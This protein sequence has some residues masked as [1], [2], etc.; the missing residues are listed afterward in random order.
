MKNYEEI[1][2]KIKLF[3]E[4]NDL[5]ELINYVNNNNIEFKN[6]NNQ[7]FDIISYTFSLY[8]KNTI[9][10]NLKDF[11]IFHYDNK[12]AKVTHILNNN[13]LNE[14]KK[15]TI[16]NNIIFKELNYKYFDILDYTKCLYEKNIISNKVYKYVLNHYNEY[17][18]REKIIEIIKTN[19]VIKLKSYIKSNNID[20]E[21]L[22][23]DWFDIREYVTSPENNI[24]VRMKLFVT[25]Y[26]DKK[27]VDIIELLK[28]NDINLVKKYM[29]KNKI[30]LKDLDDTY[31]SII[32]YVNCSTDFVY[33]NKIKYFIISYYDKNRYDV[34]E[35]IKND[36]IGQLKNYIKSN[37]IE[38]KSL[39]DKNFNLINY[40]NSYDSHITPKMKYFILSHYNK[41]RYDIVELIR[42]GKISYLKNYIEK[43]NINLEDLNDNNFNILMYINYELNNISVNMKTFVLSH[44]NKKRYDIV[45]RIRN[46][47][48]NELK[49]FIEKNDIELKYYND[50]YFDIIKYTL[51]L[52]NNGII[53]CII[54]NYVI[55]AFD[56][57]R[58][59]TVEIIKKN[60]LNELKKYI[61]ENDI[62]LD[63]L[64]G[65]Y[66]N[67]VNYTCSY[68]Y[69]IST[70]IKNFVKK[71]HN[72]K[73]SLILKT[74]INEN[75]FN[76]LKEFV[77]KKDFNFKSLNNENFDILN[78]SMNLYHS[79]KIPLEMKN[80]IFSHYDK[81]RNEIFRIINKNEL[82]ELKKY[83]K[84]NNIIFEELGD[85]FF[86]FKD[87]SDELYDKKIISFEMKLF[88]LIHYT[89]P[90]RDIINIIQNNN[91]EELK[92]YIINNDI[93]I[94][95]I[96]NKDFNIFKYSIS[97][98]KN[99]S[100][101]IIEYLLS[102]FNKERGTIVDLIKIND[103]NKVKQH[104]ENNNVKLSEINDEIFDIIKYTNS[105]Y[106]KN[107]ISLEIKGYI[108][109][110]FK[111]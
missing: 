74:Q 52:Y 11:V 71:Y 56:K 27:R 93:E 104:I 31:F 30:K 57:Q 60:D 39:N 94:K 85:K 103:I 79:G 38:L 59:L 34:V 48:F 3:I 54:K 50:K 47:Y 43:N 49:I 73:G 84:Y 16:E 83:V 6:L 107:K 17:K 2:D 55:E 80:F 90:R 33:S 102:H 97:Y 89:K 82:E 78:Y 19:N 62:K 1:I 41:K 75:R 28:K 91:I 81:K 21:Q 95:D 108:E 63:E 14:L 7:N 105:L 53:E 36:D 77:E 109:N 15:Y 111:K 58:R 61:I 99:I 64:N 18:Q 10:S 46:S 70:E 23:D 72:I 76:E 66:F 8:D 13:D 110:Y 22:N 35:L 92:T 32:E 96:N 88:I 86:N 24:T 87:L 9:S 100:I 68:L 40:I 42:N 26:F 67:I 29:E 44:L 69:N 98:V 45:E 51:S 37:N 5:N 25:H 106:N 4:K 12:I 65:H 101:D 20:L